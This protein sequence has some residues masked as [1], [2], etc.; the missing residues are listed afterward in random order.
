MRKIIKRKERER[1]GEKTNGQSTNERLKKQDKIK[2][3]YNE[4]ES[5][6]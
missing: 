2:K 4:P 6:I 3:R 5:T 1:D